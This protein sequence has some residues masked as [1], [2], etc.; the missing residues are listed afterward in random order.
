M[1]MKMFLLGLMLLS[2]CVVPA[3]NVFLTPQ[4]RALKEAEQRDLERRVLQ[5]RRDWR[6]RHN[7]Y[8]YYD[9]RDYNG[10]WR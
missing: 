1:K 6:H 10:Y 5:P 4:E 8:D 2:G 9:R 3:S 7:H